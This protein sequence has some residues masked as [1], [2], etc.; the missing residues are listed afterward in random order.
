MKEADWLACQS[1]GLMLDTL[2]RGR[3]PRKRD[4]Q[5]RLRLLGA[6]AC[7]RIW[8]LL[9]DSSLRL[10]VEKAEEYADD[11]LSREELFEAAQTASRDVERFA[12]MHWGGRYA[13]EAA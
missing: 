2:S 7:R 8:D 11:R 13:G 3:I 6:A 1:P 4:A 12:R 5:R 10:A 9:E